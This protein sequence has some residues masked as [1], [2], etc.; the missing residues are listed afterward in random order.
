MPL[1]EQIPQPVLL[2]L[3]AVFA[4][5][6]AASLIVYALVRTRPDNDYRELVLR[7]RSWWVMITI[8]AIAIVVSRTTS[9]VFFGL[10][11]FLAL[12]EFLSMVPTRRADRRGAAVGLSGDPAAVCLGRAGMVRHVHHLRAGLHVPAVA[13]ADGDPWRDERIPEGR[14]HV[15][16][17][18]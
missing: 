3:A 16:L 2:A 11:S 18:A 5:L 7:V 8:F 13:G 1:L 15:A 10:V 9:L 17:G 4:V 14:R 6:V 12:K